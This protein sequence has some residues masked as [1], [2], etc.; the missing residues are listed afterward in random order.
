LPRFWVLLVWPDGRFSITGPS[1]LRPGLQL[2]GNLARRTL[3]SCVVI[4]SEL[5]IQPSCS[6]LT[7]EPEPVSVPTDYSD[8]SLGTSKL[9]LT[10]YPATCPKSERLGIIITNVS[11]QAG[12]VRNPVNTCG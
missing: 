6:G 12:V 3:R 5:T 7:N 11:R 9:A 10:K 8:P 4:S 1:V 2:T